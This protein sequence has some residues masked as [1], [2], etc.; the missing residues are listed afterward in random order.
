MKLTKNNYRNWVSNS[1]KNRVKATLKRLLMISKR[2]L[3]VIVATIVF[4]G[5]A[6]A[7]LAEL[8]MARYQV[9]AAAE[10]GAADWAPGEYQLA[11]DALEVAR[12]QIENHEYRSAHKTLQLAH[13]YAEVARIESEQAAERVAERERQQAEKARTA[14]AQRQ[15]LLAEEQ[16]ARQRQLELEQQQQAEAEAAARAAAQAAKT[17]EPPPLPLPVLPE[18]TRVE[19]YEV[20]PGQNLADIA[21]LPEVYDDDLLWPLIY[22]AN[23]DQIKTPGEIS[24]GQIL[25]IPQNKTPEERE[26]ARREARELNLF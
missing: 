16:A 12:Q 25:D 14:A 21:G 17:A 18:Q 4:A 1:E 2:F 10:V 23:R 11:R 15:R 6:K 13:R 24:A 26:A 3:P 9:Q 8:E 22:R 20:K 7:P 5:C 19:R